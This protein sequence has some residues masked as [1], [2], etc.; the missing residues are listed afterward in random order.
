MLPAGTVRRSV[1][2]RV[3]VVAVALG[4]ALSLAGCSGSGST[5]PS[6]SP[7]PSHSKTASKPTPT[8][9]PTFAALQY[10]CNSILP[11][12]TLQVFKSKQG[13]GFTLQNDYLQRMENIGSNLVTFNTY[14]GILCQWAYP[15]AANSVDYAFSAITS[16]QAS[17][18]QA[19]LTSTGYV[20]TPKD[21]GTLFANTDTADYPDE[22]LFIDGYWFQASSDNLM[23]LIV[24]NVFV[25]SP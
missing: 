17:T 24:D 6:A 18:Q 5:R 3:A 2:L 7:K 16:D 9:T 8:P 13:A 19:T 20:G 14:G 22:Y 25:T 10:T 12:A 1:W 23:D 11:P 4:A 21:H 15:N